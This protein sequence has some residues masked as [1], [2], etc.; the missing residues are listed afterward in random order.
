MLIDR[1]AGSRESLAVEGLDLR[2]L[3]T[4][5]RLRQGRFTDVIGAA[6]P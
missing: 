3:F 2:S 1:Q 6:R 4:M 5:S